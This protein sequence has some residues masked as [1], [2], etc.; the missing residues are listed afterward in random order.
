MSGRAH[1]RPGWPTKPTVARLAAATHEW[2]TVL[3]RELAQVWSAVDTE[4][5]DRKRALEAAHAS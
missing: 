2:L 1:V 4:R 3:D 5:A